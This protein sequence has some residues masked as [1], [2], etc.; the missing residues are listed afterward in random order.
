MQVAV[1]LA[2]KKPIDALLRLGDSLFLPERQATQSRPSKQGQVRACRIDAIGT[3]A[4]QAQCHIRD[5]G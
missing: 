2:V 1:L 3:T 5:I 4:D